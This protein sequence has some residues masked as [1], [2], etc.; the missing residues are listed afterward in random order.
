MR[1]LVATET[2]SAAAVS[3][4]AGGSL[5]QRYAA[6]R[7]M[8]GHL[9]EP[10][11]PEDQNLQSMADASPVKWHLAH[12]SWF[13][14]TFLL[15]PH[16]RGYRPFHKDFTYL[17][18][19]YY[20]AVGE[21]PERPQRSLMSRPGTEVVLRYRAHVDAAMA[22]LLEQDLAPELASV[23]ELGLNHEQQHQELILTDIQHAFWSQPLRPA[24]R[25]RRAEDPGAPSSLEWFAFPGGMDSVGHKGD[26]FCL[27]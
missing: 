1:V 23:V 19:S 3:E 25:E 6:V 7:R 12:T 27:R 21:R 14:E 9:A 17:F 13:F 8:S 10:L 4:S 11:T 5:A 2:S 26:G 16:L 24:Y 15:L 18:N 20:N 22:Q